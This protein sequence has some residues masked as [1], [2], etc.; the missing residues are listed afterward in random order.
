MGLTILVIGSGGREHAIVEKL[1]QSSH[2]GQVYCAKGNPGMQQAKVQLVDI[3]ETDNAALCAFAKKQGVDWTFVGPEVPL[4]NGIVDHFQQEGLLIFGPTK[5]AAMIEGSKDFAKQLMNK[6]QIPT[7]HHQTVVTVEAAVEYLA[8]CSLPIVIKA[9]GL[10]AGKGVVIAQTKAAALEAVTEM[11]EQKRFGASGSKVVIETFLQGEEFSLFA[12]VKGTAVYPMVPVQDHKRAYEQDQG[13]NTG[14]MGAYSPVPAISEAL[15]DETIDKVLKPVAQA[16][17]TENCAFT[18]ILY[19]GLI[20]TAQGVKVIEFNARF[21]DPETQVV[22]Q[23]LT[24]DFA[25]IIDDLLHD[26]KPIIKWKS[27]GFNLGVVVAAQGYPGAY[28]TGIPLPHF[29]LSENEHLYYAG[30]QQAGD[31]IIS[32]GGRIYLLEASGETLKQAQQNVY[33]H[34]AQAKTTGT[35]YRKD[36]GYRSLS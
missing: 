1:S 34:L 25:V 5:K 27:T 13:P 6:Y 10:A 32:N 4:L 2:V 12:F 35:F 29:S 26:K 23:R 17:V 21:G 18:G 19:A 3:E 36:I 15:V 8:D 9:D 14:G 11:L 31:Q 16:L 20:A 24:S 22:L 28:Q 7:A 30:V 33:Q